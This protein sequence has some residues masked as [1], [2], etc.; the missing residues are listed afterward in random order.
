MHDSLFRHVANAILGQTPTRNEKANALA[1]VRERE[2]LI[3]LCADPVDGA[4][5]APTR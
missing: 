5:L 1:Q 4:P 3:D 2:F